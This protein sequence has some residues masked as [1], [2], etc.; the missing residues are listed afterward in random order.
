MLRV[1]IFSILVSTPV[2]LGQ[3]RGRCPNIPGLP[4]DIYRAPGIW[5]LHSK[6]T[7]DYDDKMKCVRIDWSQP[8]GLNFT[9]SINGISTITNAPTSIV[10]EGRDGSPTFRN[11]VPVLGEVDVDYY[12]LGHNYAKWAILYYCNEKYNSHIE[13]ALVL[14]RQKFPDQ[15]G[16]NQFIDESYNYWGLRKPQFS[17]IVQNC[18]N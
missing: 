2:I 4:R 7:N 15:R 13:Q 1:L 12:I 9:L 17:R 6:S 16:L 8:K 3:Q 18:R 14:T 5:Y 10:I 11:H